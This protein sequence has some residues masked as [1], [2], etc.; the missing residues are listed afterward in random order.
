[1]VVEAEP[2]L[3]NV[4]LVGRCARS[5]SP[6]LRRPWGSGPWPRG[7][8]AAAGPARPGHSAGQGALSAIWDR[9]P[10]AASAAALGFCR[11]ALREAGAEAPGGAGGRGPWGHRWGPAVLVGPPACGQADVAAVWVVPRPQCWVFPHEVRGRAPRAPA[12]ARPPL[13]GISVRLPAVTP[14]RSSAE[15]PAAARTLLCRL[16]CA[17]AAEDPAPAHA[18]SRGLTRA[19]PVGVC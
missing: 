10:A 14:F 18:G 8:G 16:P 3:G 1:M 2:I 6:A 19:V 5:L 15:G 11:E 17:A 13:G 12:R 4:R 9:C 7:P